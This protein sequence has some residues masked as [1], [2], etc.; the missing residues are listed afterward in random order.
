MAEKP[1]EVKENVSET[2]PETQEVVE[3]PAE[4]TQQDDTQQEQQEI[5]VQPD[6]VAGQ[7]QAEAVDERGVPWKNNAFEWKRKA[8]DLAEKLP[9]LVE[10]KIQQA[11]QQFG[12]GQQEKEYTVSQL[13]AY[14]IEHPEYRPWVEEQKAVLIQKKLSKDMDEKI[15]ADRKRQEGEVRKQQALRYVMDNYSD[16]FLKNPQGQIVGWNNAHPLTQQIGM[17]MK[18]PRFANDPEGLAGAADIAYGRM[19]RSQKPIQQQKEIKLKHEVKDLQK[20]TL[21]EGGGK[22]STVV[23]NPVRDALSKL[24]KTGSL[25]DAE[26]AL[27][28]IIKR[29]TTTE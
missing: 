4:T 11:F 5:P 28:E 20:K 18:D 1:E 9:S 19:M 29:S 14:A 3:Q 2:S 7:P 25:K 6:T 12:S 17:I 16:A 27:A 8:E 23:A 21:A 22:P 13:E 24:K 26:A 10:E 15:Q